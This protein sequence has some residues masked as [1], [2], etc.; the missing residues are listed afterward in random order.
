M[1]W[2]LKLLLW[3]EAAPLVSDNF[4]LASLSPISP[5]DIVMQSLVLVTLF[6]LSGNNLRKDVAL[7]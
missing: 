7:S 3:N 5:A 1:D 2:G 6:I 4:I